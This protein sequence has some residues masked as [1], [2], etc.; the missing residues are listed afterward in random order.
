MVLSAHHQKSTCIVMDHSDNVAT[1]LKD[2]K[3]GEI[4]NYKKNGQESSL[5]IEENIPFGHK[6]ALRFI[7]VSENVLKYG[8]VIGAASK[9][10]HPGFHVHIHNIEGIRGRGD[11]KEGVSKNENI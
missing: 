9:D 7:S 8:E 11:K 4:L 2:V 5:T 10:I 6:V 3:K 1:M